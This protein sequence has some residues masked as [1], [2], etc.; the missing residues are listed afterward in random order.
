MD[1][2]IMERESLTLESANEVFK[3]FDATEEFETFI[4]SFKITSIVD[5]AFSACM[6]VLQQMTSMAPNDVKEIAEKNLKG[7]QGSKESFV[8]DFESNFKRIVAGNLLIIL[9]WVHDE[10]SVRDFIKLEMVSTDEAT[11]TH[12]TA[13]Q[14][15]DQMIMN[16]TKE[17]VFCT[18]AGYIPKGVSNASQYVIVSNENG[19]KAVVPRS[20]LG[21][22]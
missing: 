7:F 13:K 9:D 12:N 19:E 22:I 14:I 10:E 21:I 2:M 16:I 4:K 6:N 3:R 18:Y 11:Q 5:N 8:S 17:Y 1:K 15:V 20:V